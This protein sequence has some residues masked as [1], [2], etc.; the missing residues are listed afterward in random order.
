MN[1]L[2]N[3]Y[4][5]LT[6]L[7]AEVKRYDTVLL[8]TLEDEMHQTNVLAAMEQVFDGV[9]ELRFFVEGLKI[10]PLL[11][12]R[13]MRGIMLTPG[14]FRFSFVNGKMEIGKYVR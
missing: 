4:R 3:V 7:L 10:V 12:I 8:A 2:E 13:K 6:Q 5:F 1:P 9:I 14:Y 11:R